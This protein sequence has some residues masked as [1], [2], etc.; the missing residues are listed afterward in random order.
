MNESNDTESTSFE[1]SRADEGQD[2][3]VSQSDHLSEEKPRL[4]GNLVTPDNSAA[5]NITHKDI[6]ITSSE[7]EQDGAPMETGPPDSL[8]TSNSSLASNDTINLDTVAQTSPMPSADTASQATSKRTKDRESKKPTPVV[9]SPEDSEVVF[10]RVLRSA[11][12]KSHATGAAGEKEG[13]GRSFLVS[14]SLKMLKR[15]LQCGE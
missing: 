9:S 10:D 2:D 8:S 5:V 6:Y 12:R 13:N 7:S 15:P 1:S 11:S 3:K 14:W 4:P